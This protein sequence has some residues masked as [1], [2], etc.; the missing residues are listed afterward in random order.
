MIPWSLFLLTHYTYFAVIVVATD[1]YELD[2]LPMPA[3]V[4][5]AVAP[6]LTGRLQSTASLQRGHESLDA[7]IE[8]D[9]MLARP[10]E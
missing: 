9:P 2:R 8:T 6:V 4:D 5:P 7:T 3:T 1:Q 10:R